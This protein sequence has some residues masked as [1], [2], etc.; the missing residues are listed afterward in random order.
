MKKAFIFAGLISATSLFS[1]SQ[2]TTQA[3]SQEVIETEL[4][5]MQPEEAVQDTIKGSIK[6]EAVGKIGNAD[7]QINY[8]APG[9]KGR[10]IWGGLVPYGQVWVTG[11]HMATNLETNKDLL[12]GGK[13]LKAGKYALFTIPGKDEWTV[14]INKNWEQHLADNYAEADDIL[15]VNVKP[16]MLGKHQERLKYELAEQEAGKG[17]LR[18]FWEKVGITI[19]IEV[20][21]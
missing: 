1:C 14:I 15:R 21:K 11:A 20:K 4:N 10:V 3:D 13:E 18:I 12:I 16:E 5:E 8:H 9:V 6:S 7:I 2:E 19:P 17:A